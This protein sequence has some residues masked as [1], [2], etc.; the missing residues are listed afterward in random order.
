M[1]T[2]NIELT[3]INCG[4]AR[5]ILQ[6]GAENVQ[7]Q[8]SEGL[9]LNYRC[10]RNATDFSGGSISIGQVDAELPA[11]TIVAGLYIVCALV[12]MA[13]LFYLYRKGVSPRDVF[14]WGALALIVLFLGPLIT[15]IFYRFAA[16]N[17][18]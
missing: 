3:R 8:L 1:P 17:N 5:Q 14:Y 4:D 10:N 15:I 16:R 11:M 9:A 2:I 7:R 13:A 12:L 18:G 6:D